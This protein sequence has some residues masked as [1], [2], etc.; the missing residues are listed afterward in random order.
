MSDRGDDELYIEP[1]T[2]DSVHG[3]LSAGAALDETAGNLSD[4]DDVSAGM[5]IALS[6]T[7][8]TSKLP[9]LA[10]DPVTVTV[11]RRIKPGTEAQYLRWCDE[12]VATLRQFTGCL[13]AGLLHPGPDGGEYQIVF[14]FVD[15][16][17]LRAWERSPERARLTSAVAPLV[18]SERL[19][20]T[21]GVDDW[22]ELPERAEPRR[23]LWSRVVTD[24]LWVYPV[25]FLAALFVAPLLEA[26]PVEYRVLTSS[27]LITLAMRIGVGP[28]RKRLRSRR[29]L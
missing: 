9:R 22:F 11:A 7:V 19:Q 1:A 25:A 8:D 13:G 15:G 29:T 21:V 16:M 10:P 3:S 20:R 28:L 12:M 23:S 18:V 2:D 24:V 6:G 17:H 27:A 26:L 14:R 5:A 4:A